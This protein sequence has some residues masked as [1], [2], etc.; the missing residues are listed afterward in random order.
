MV[1]VSTYW[2][3]ARPG[4]SSY[5][6]SLVARAG[7]D[8]LELRLLFLTCFA[9]TGWSG[10]K[11]SW[12]DCVS[13]SSETETSRLEADVFLCLALPGKASGKLISNIPSRCNLCCEI[14]Y[15]SYLLSVLRL[16]VVLAIFSMVV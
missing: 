3:S 12:P 6:S 2:L 5:S 9:A 1:I 8:F 16:T 14:F 13:G 10:T 11:S 7:S 15:C 4:S